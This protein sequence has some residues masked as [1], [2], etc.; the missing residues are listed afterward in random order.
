VQVNG[1]EAPPQLSFDDAR[2]A[3]PEI[4]VAV[5][6]IEPGGLVT[7]EVHSGGEVYAFVAA[8]ADQAMALAFPPDVPGD[9]FG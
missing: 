3:Y 2:R 4:G 6:A 8:T 7:V 9:V 1:V 5:Y